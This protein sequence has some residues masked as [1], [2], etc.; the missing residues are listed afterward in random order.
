MAI[1]RRIEGEADLAGIHAGG[2]GYVFYPFGRK[3]HHASCSTVPEMRLNPNEPRWYA[4]DD[5]SAVAYQAKRLSD[6]PSAKP[7]QAVSCCAERI[8]SSVLVRSGESVGAT[9]KTHVARGTAK[10]DVSEVESDWDC[11]S[12]AL[13]VDLWTCKRT[14]FTTDQSPS[15]KAMIRAIAP[16]VA[17]LRCDGRSR[18]QG[19]FTS[20]DRT[21]PQ[22][23][24]ENIAFY[25]FGEAPF[26]GCGDSISFE[27]SY[28]KAPPA[29]VGPDHG[30]RFHHQWSMV[31]KD[32]P[33][34][35]WRRGNDVCTWKGVP[36]DLNG[37]LALNAWRA[38]REH[39]DRI[40]AAGLLS[41]ADEFGVEVTLSLPAGARRSVVKDL[42]P[43][44]DGPLAGLQRADAVAPEIVAKLLGR[45]WGRTMDEQALLRLISARRPE[46][47]FPRAPFNRNGLD[48]CD[49]NCV[50][51]L[52]RLVTQGAVASITGSVF[53]VQAK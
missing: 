48:P 5:A 9:L 6:Y 52:V 1:V 38:M 29:P 8:P 36:I 42:K 31:S 46:V 2:R 32:A 21:V 13:C 17:A 18:L 35:H 11:V 15:Q 40:K 27:R 37:D 44:V 24:A 47:V 16:R 7:M 51:G 12:S 19:V 49:E 33:F 39:P 43:L 41:A 34:Q 4:P 23:D 20:D 10:P 50:A 45:A 53:K 3:V 28:H 30:H 26:S 22:P 25:N 14:P